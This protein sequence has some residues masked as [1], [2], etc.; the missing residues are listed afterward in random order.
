MSFYG[1][2]I[3]QSL[4]NTGVIEEF[5]VVAQKQ[6]GSWKLLL[7]S[8][9]DHEIE[10]RINILQDHMIPIADDCWYAHFFNGETMFAVY[11][12]AAFKTTIHPKDWDE[13]IQYGL[14][15]QVPI[16]QLDFKPCTKEEAF[17]LF[18]L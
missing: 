11:Q 13:I 7:V 4:R 5:D 14:E 15:H 10:S 3:E 1:I 12:D 6:A 2:V 18:G 8:V 9:P 16:E 17:L